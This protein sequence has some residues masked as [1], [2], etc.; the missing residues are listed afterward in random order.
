MSLVLS[1]AVLASSN[2]LMSRVLYESNMQ[3]F[4]MLALLGWG[5]VEVAR[6]RPKLG[7]IVRPSLPSILVPLAMH[8]YFTVTGFYFGFYQQIPIIGAVGIA[9][10]ALGLWLHLT[11]WA[12]WRRTQG[13][14]TT[15]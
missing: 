3:L 2:L 9:M 11:P 10:L 13:P 7:G 12:R 5:I 4:G 14:D 15:R 8:I 1:L 6:A